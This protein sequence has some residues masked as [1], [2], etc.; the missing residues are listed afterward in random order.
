I[1]V[2]NDIIDKVE[3]IDLVSEV[4]YFYFTTLLMANLASH[5]SATLLV[6]RYQSLFP[7][8]NGAAE[9]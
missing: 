4:Q 8:A 2:T 9:L 6:Q 3:T 7:A 5:L 1:Y